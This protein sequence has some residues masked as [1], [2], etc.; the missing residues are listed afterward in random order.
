MRNAGIYVSHNAIVIVHHFRR[1]KMILFSFFQE[2]SWASSFKIH[3]DA[4]PDS[5]YILTEND[6]I[7]IS[8]KYDSSALCT[9]V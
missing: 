3:H 9:I 6:V 1:N 2:T 8:G 7:D 5:L 4:A